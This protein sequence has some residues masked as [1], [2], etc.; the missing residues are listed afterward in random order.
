V[1]VVYDSRRDQFP[2]FVQ[3][4]R[5]LEPAGATPEGL[6]FK[7]TMDLILECKDTHDVYFINFSDGE[8]SFGYNSDTALG[9]S[10]KHRGYREYFSYAG[11]VATKHT[12]TMVQQLR[13]ANVKVLSYFITETYKHSYNG[14]SAAKAV[15]QKMYGEDAVMVNVENA[16]E[17]LRTLNSRL[18]VRG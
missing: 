12:R 11:E 15:F 4:M 13:D 14:P 7:A 5:K 1:S 9:K 10:G 3:H 2:K 17:V 16:S 8:P 6:C 18:L